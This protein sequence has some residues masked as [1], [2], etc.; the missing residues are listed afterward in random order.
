MTPLGPLTH[1]EVELDSRGVLSVW[2]DRPE[3]RNAMNQAL[4][5]SLSALFSALRAPTQSAALNLERARV[6]VL[7]GRGGHFCAGGDLEE[8]RFASPEALVGHNRAFGRMLEEATACPIP[9][10]CVLEGAAMGG[11]FGLASVSDLCLSL[12][13]TRLALPEV[14]LGIIPAQIA[15]FVARRIGHQ[16]AL[17][18][19]LTGAQISA[20]RAQ[21]LGLIT[22]LY[23]GERS[24]EDG[25]AELITQLLKGAPN[26]LRVTKQ[27]I[28]ES[29]EAQGDELSALLDQA[30]ERFK[31]Q[32]CSQEG[33]EGLSAF[34]NKRSPRW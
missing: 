27:L 7:R 26:A 32:A 17:Q 8:M 30:S 19:A 20:E 23:E 2:L 33:T 11:G 34:L 28:R 31:R 21:E 6:C 10:L 15:P 5:R 16:A 9:L 24:L 1:L 12:R 25:L 14:R 4:V 18:L 29:V 13:T 22:Q 3:R